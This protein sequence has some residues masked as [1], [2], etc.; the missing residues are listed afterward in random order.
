M[1]LISRFLLF[2]LGWRTQ[3]SLGHLQK[4]VLI[5]APHTS[6]W[7]LFYTLLMA[8]NLKT[9]IYWM[10]KDSIFTKP[11]AG[12]MKWLG[13]IPIDRSKSNNV[14]GQS[15]QMFNQNEKMVLTVPPSGTRSRVTYWKTGF[16]HIAN[17]AKVP[18]ALG[19][20]DYGLKI[21][22]IGPTFRTTGDIEADMKVISAFYAGITGKYPLQGSGAIVY[23]PRQDKAA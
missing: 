18:I 8:F 11:F 2:C 23:K 13:G 1:R 19:F 17:N 5:A 21:G 14:V 20:L 7:D 9:G 10:G 3:G 16:Y 15:I 4:C 6:N 22:G 12:I